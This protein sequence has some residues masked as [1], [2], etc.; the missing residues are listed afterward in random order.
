MTHLGTY[1]RRTGFDRPTSTELDG[2]THGSQ[3]RVWILGAVL[4]STRKHSLRIPTKEAR[5]ATGK[6]LLTERFQAG[7]SSVREA[8]RSARQPFIHGKRKVGF[9]SSH[10]ALVSR[11]RSRDTSGKF[12]TDNYTGN[13]FGYSEGRA[14]KSRDRSTQIF[15]KSCAEAAS[16]SS[17]SGLSSSATSL[18][19]S[20]SASAP[21]AASAGAS[22][23]L[24][25]MG[26]IGSRQ[27]TPTT[28]MTAT[29][30]AMT[31][32]QRSVM[33]SKHVNWY[34]SER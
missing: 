25:I 22:I 7:L 6:A 10:A 31:Q 34:P 30:A 33:Q 18:P 26:A 2:C 14:R 24:V 16:M 3:S 4:P 8:L 32:I 15:F 21:G 19:T 12:A 11:F 28:A 20:A 17:T 1:T 9:C 5:K 29:G 27:R 23:L 13:Q